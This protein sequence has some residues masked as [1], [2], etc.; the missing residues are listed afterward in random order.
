MHRTRIA[1]GLILSTVHCFSISEE[2]QETL[3]AEGGSGESWQDL[4]VHGQMV[5]TA[6]PGQAGTCAWI[7]RNKGVL[8][9][10][11]LVSGRE[12]WAWPIRPNTDMRGIKYRSWNSR[13]VLSQKNAVVRT[14]DPQQPCTLIKHLHQ[15]FWGFFMGLFG[16]LCLWYFPDTR[17]CCSC[18]CPQSNTTPSTC[19]CTT[20][21]L[22]PTAFVFQSHNEFLLPV[23][24]ALSLESLQPV[25]WS[26]R[27][28]DAGSGFTW[29][30]NKNIERHV[31]QVE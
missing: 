26:F 4:V 28:K 7:S 9:L 8:T 21:D 6:K 30:R 29:R 23:R 12:K 2:V 13:F 25:W 18:L 17:N 31:R 24:A 20:G 19:T 11:R 3:W 14:T 10:F 27:I 15:V 16:F 5:G 22:C 1:P